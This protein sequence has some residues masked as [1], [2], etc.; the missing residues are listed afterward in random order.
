M[1]EGIPNKPPEPINVQTVIKNF[2]KEARLR[3]L[4]AQALIR[5]Y[6]IRWKELEKLVEKL[7]EIINRKHDQPR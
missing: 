1:P 4:E 3:I 7:E 6:D 2:L 5:S